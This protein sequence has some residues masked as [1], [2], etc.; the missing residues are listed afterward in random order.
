MI[1]S[2]KITFGYGSQPLLQ[3]VHLHVKPGTFN[4]FIGP[5]GSGKTTLL[6]IM[7]G[8]LLPDDG[9]ILLKKKNIQDY[10]P[11]EKAQIQA[12]IFQGSAIRFPFSC[13]EVVLMGLYPHREMG[14]GH[15]SSD[16]EE[17]LKFMAYTDTDHFAER[18]I[19]ELSG[20][21][22]QRVLLARA[23]IQKPE[24]LFLDE[25]FSAMDV[26][27]RAKGL[28]LVKE[29]VVKTGLTVV[30]VMHDLNMAYTFADQVVLLQ[31]GTVYA[32]G[33]ADQV[34]TEKNIESVFK[35]P[36]TRV[37]GVGFLPAGLRAMV[38]SGQLKEESAS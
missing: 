22:M 34:M 26:E 23:L 18:P 21:E 19:T 2:K 17:A 31:E 12:A 9:E 16:I 20:G 38:E 37:D 1:Q 14:S 33:T 3:D 36:M 15:G 6:K 7:C 11:K 24:V 8:E 27:K 32:K 29:Y 28:A 5:N 13:L 4:A 25:A 10:K 30:A 35:I